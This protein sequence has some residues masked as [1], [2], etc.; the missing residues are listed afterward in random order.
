MPVR[1]N[2]DISVQFIPQRFFLNNWRK[3]KRVKWEI[4]RSGAWKLAMKA[5]GM[6]R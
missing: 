2:N 5:A 3:K 4:F 1:S 6:C